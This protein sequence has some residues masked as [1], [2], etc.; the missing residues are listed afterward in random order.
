MAFLTSWETRRKKR[1]LGHT[2]KIVLKTK[3]YLAVYTEAAW[4]AI[5]PTPTK[6]FFSLNTEKSSKE[7]GLVSTKHLDYKDLSLLQEAS[8]LP[9]GLGRAVEVKK[10][11][12]PFWE[13]YQN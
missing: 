5:L 10:A 3:K 1:G 12:T 4:H 13:A 8:L 11:P 7:H 6:H 9:L 2:V